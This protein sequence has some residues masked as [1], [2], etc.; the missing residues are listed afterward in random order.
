MPSPS[1]ST[2]LGSCP[3]NSPPTRFHTI[4]SGTVFLTFFLYE[5]PGTQRLFARS[6]ARGIRTKWN[7]RAFHCERRR[8]SSSSFTN[9][10][11]RPVGQGSSPPGPLIR[12]SS[13]AANL[14]SSSFIKVYL[15][16]LLLFKKNAPLLATATKLDP[17][18][19]S[20]ASIG[21]GARLEVT[22]A[23]VFL[24]V[25]IIKINPSF[26]ASFATN[27]P[28]TQIAASNIVRG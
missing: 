20:L 14:T 26:V 23:L 1:N 19:R 3:K 10:Y 17:L 2:R 5:L 12:P 25:P 16:L 24:R 22:R 9:K 21:R 27:L 7:L 6:S 28:L 13:I 8:D 18:S 4:D 15:V 11:G